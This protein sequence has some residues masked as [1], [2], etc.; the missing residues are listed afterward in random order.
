ME[1]RAEH[2]LREHLPHLRAVEPSATP[3]ERVLPLGLVAGVLGGVALA[4]PL[5]IYGWAHAGHSALELPMAATAWLF[6]LEHFAQNEYRFWPIV[7]GVALLLA[8]FALHGA[9]FA[10]LEERLRTLPETVVG[11]L[12]LSFYSWL[13]FWYV[14][15]PIA[16]DGAPFRETAT[17]DAFVAPNWT[18]ILGFALFGVGTGVAYWMLRSARSRRA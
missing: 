9:A 10:F 11:G 1:A 7:I 16:R 8:Y 2:W 4:L 15:L 14:L 3:V 5:L 18:W 17:V 6:G 12:M 13:L